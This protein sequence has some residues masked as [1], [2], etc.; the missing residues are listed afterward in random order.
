M[1]KTEINKL[2]ADEAIS[3]VTELVEAGE[4]TFELEEGAELTGVMAKE[5]LATHFADYTPPKKAEGFY[6]ILKVK[7]Y[8]DE[9][10]I[11][12]S[13]L[14]FSE[15]KFERLFKSPERYVECYEGEIPAP[16]VYKLAEQYKV[17]VMDG[18][19]ERTVEEL[20]NEIV[21]DIV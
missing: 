4:L 5:L 7:S 8:I 15:R 13:G 20:L 11:L 16:R 1:T 3:K 18:K 19:K 12:P 6:Y 17:S 2:K 21:T 9:D 10:T 14:Y